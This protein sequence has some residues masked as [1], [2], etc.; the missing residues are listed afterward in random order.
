MSCEPFFL[1]RVSYQLFHRLSPRRKL[2]EIALFPKLKRSLTKLENQI[3][4]DPSAYFAERTFIPNILSSFLLTLAKTDSLL[5]HPRDVDAKMII[6][7]I[8]LCCRFLEFLIDLLSQLP[9]RR[10]L[11][12]YLEDKHLLTHCKRTALFQN[13]AGKLFRDMVTLF[14]SAM[15]FPIDNQQGVSLTN[16]EMESRHCAK[17]T[18]F[19]RVVYKRFREKVP[20]VA[21]VASSVLSDAKKLAGLLK[22]LTDADIL[23]LCDDLCICDRVTAE[24][25][26]NARQF[27]I[28]LL[29][30]RHTRHVVDHSEINGVGLYPDEDVLWNPSIIPPDKYTGRTPLALPKQGMQYLSIQ[31]YLL[32]NFMLLQYETSYS[33]KLDIEDSIRKMNPIYDPSTQN[34][35]FMRPHRRTLPLAGLEIIKVAPPQL[36]FTRPA[37]V[38]AE[39]RYDLRNIQHDNV[40]REWESIGQHDIFILVGL[41]ERVSDSDDVRSQYGVTYVRGCEVIDIHDNDGNVSNGADPTI[42]LRGTSRRARVRLDPVIYQRDVLSPETSELYS[43]P[44]SF[45]F[46]L[47]RRP[48]ASNFKAIL[49]TI[50]DCLNKP[51]VPTWMNDILL[52]YGSADSA[53]YTSLEDSDDEEDDTTKEDYDVVY[54]QPKPKTV[55]L[56]QSD[57]IKPPKVVFSESQSE[58]IRIANHPGLSLVVG[59]PGTGKTDVAV[60]I[61]NNLYQKYPNQKTLVIT[62]SNAALND[63]FLKTADMN[64]DP[65]HLLRLGSGVKHLESDDDFSKAGRVEYILQR[66]LDLLDLVAKLC[67]SIGVDTGFA[68]TCEA[69]LHF[70]TQHVIPRWEAFQKLLSE[71]KDVDS[72]KGKYPFM[73]F[74]DDTVVPIFH[75]V[76]TPDQLTQLTSACWEHIQSTF[77]EVDDCRSFELFRTAGDRGNYLL[78]KQARIVAMTCT[79]AALKRRDFIRLGFQYDTIIMEES[80]QILDIET[81]IPMML[82]EAPNDVDTSKR[83]KRIVLIGD[84]NQLPPI[85]QNP[86]FQKYCHLD[87]SMFSRFIRLGVPSVSLT[88]Q[89]RMRSELADLFRWRYSGLT[90]MPHVKTN[91]EFLLANPGFTHT[92][93]FVHVEGNEYEPQP[94]FFQNL[95]EAETLVRTYMYMR[96]IGYASSRITILTTYNGQRHLI[97]DILDRMCPLHSYYG[98]HPKVTTVDKY[99]GQQNDFVLLSL[100]RTERAG[101][102][103]D[104]RRLVVALS[105][106]RLGLYIFGKTDLF[107]EVW[108]LKPAM[109]VL[110]SRP[111]KLSLC[112]DEVK[113][114]TTRKHDEAGTEQ[115]TLEPE[116]LEELVEKM[117]SIVITAADKAESEARIKQIQE[118]EERLKARKEANYIYS[119][120]WVGKKEGWFFGNGEFGIGYYKDPVAPMHVSED[121]KRKMYILPPMDKRQKTEEVAATAD[122]PTPES[123]DDDDDDDDDDEDD[124]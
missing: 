35:T 75:D 107:S 121:V 3:Q 64:I 71:N 98:K 100:V 46:I 91:P 94:H 54:R 50:R 31:D 61:I 45:S 37:D 113:N 96:L 8:I 28:S 109:K 23:D 74:F 30:E 57:V 25:T 78:T 52:G 120:K 2:L 29:A 51:D 80:A 65:R 67:R 48:E 18:T 47:R 34:V 117:A 11:H 63:I 49:E 7:Y 77:D 114:T 26:D 88:A 81:L 68:H 4:K 1:K 112:T 38:R 123:D 92:Y 119:D 90:D 116:S 108:E 72:V 101:H 53:H 13:D 115:L 6:D 12:S 118:A 36:G 82:Q 40:R 41:T 93:Q 32:R 102:I 110:L 66:R 20:D 89:G 99:Q 124:A 73:A 59:P 87:Q 44:G 103:W 86:T 62:H 24:H 56:Y 111:T 60:Q 97:K 122:K 16:A 42:E 58:A 5:S 15:V 69:S 17:V 9:T 19:Q 10:F 14:Q 70:Y 84:H 22:P 76:S 104:T 105:R 43:T 33:I 95:K 55:Q 85:V 106:A 83:L 79:H 21:M 27:M 39:I